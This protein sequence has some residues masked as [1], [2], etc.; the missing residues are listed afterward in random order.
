MDNIYPNLNFQLYIENWFIYY[1][2]FS[3]PECH[4]KL[5][6]GTMCSVLCFRQGDRYNRINVYQVKLHF[7]SSP[8]ALFVSVSTQRLRRT[9]SFC[10]S[11]R[12]T[13]HTISSSEEFLSLWESM[14]FYDLAVRIRTPTDSRADTDSGIPIF[15]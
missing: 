10:S 14:E 12:S 7:L 4:Q 11:G 15:P 1:E 8:Q 9:V 3:S 13:L 6:D 2:M 5:I